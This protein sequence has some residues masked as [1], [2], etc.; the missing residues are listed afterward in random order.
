MAAALG[1][2]AG[3]WRRG[4]A[5]PHGGV[6]GV[7]GPLGSFPLTNAFQPPSWARERREGVWGVF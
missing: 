2:G 3:G 5:S 1:G 6:R 4:R 7:R